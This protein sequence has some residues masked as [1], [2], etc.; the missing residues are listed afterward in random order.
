MQKW[1]TVR[2]LAGGDL[3]LSSQYIK[4]TK[5]EQMDLSTGSAEVIIWMQEP[6][7]YQVLSEM[8]GTKIESEYQLISIVRQMAKCRP[9]WRRCVRQATV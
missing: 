1:N 6:L 9:R 7:Y 4:R 5:L 8:T 3:E 2:D